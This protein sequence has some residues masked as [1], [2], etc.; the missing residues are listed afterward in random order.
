[1]S[2]HGKIVQVIGAVVDAAFPIDN[3][4]EIL[5]AVT[6]DFKVDGEDKQLTLEVQQHLGSS[7]YQIKEFEGHYRFF[8][9]DLKTD[10]TFRDGWLQGLILHDMCHVSQL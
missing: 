2:N 3:V 5:D 7:T 4:P 1:M 8:E 9:K 6:I 10:L